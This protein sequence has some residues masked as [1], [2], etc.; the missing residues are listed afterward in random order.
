MGFSNNSKNTS[1]LRPIN[2]IRFET[3]GNIIFIFLGVCGF[4]ICITPEFIEDTLLNNIP[5]LLRYI[6]LTVCTT[7]FS[8]SLYNLIRGIN[9]SKD[10]N[11]LYN[12]TV[13]FFK[14]QYKTL[15]LQDREK[16][17]GL[18]DI[19]KE[20][21]D[22]ALKIILELKNISQNQILNRNNEENYFCDIICNGAI[23]GFIPANDIRDNKDGI[24]DSIIEYLT[25]GFSIRIIM[26]NHKLDYL[27]Q[28]Q[29]D[30]TFPFRRKDMINS[31]SANSA[32][33]EIN[34]N[35]EILR[36]ALD[37]IM[38]HENLRNKNIGKIIVRFTNC[39]PALQYHRVGNKVFV[40]SR[41]LGSEYISRPFINEYQNEENN[42]NAFKHYKKFFD[43]LW[44][45]NN[46]SWSDKNLSSYSYG[47]L[48][49]KPTNLVINPSLVFG[50]GIIAG[51]MK[52][53][54][55]TLVMILR[56]IDKTKIGPDAQPVRAFFTVINSS[57]NDKGEALRYNLIA[58]DRRDKDL[59]RDEIKDYPIDLR[60]VIGEAV[61]S[62]KIIFRTVNKSEPTGPHI[63][64]S[65]KDTILK[66]TGRI[67]SNDAVAIS[68]SVP[69]NANIDDKNDIP[70]IKYEDHD[71]IF[72][73]KKK[74]KY[75]SKKSRTIAVLTFE[76]HAS[77][78]SL[79][80]IPEKITINDNYYINVTDSEDNKDKK[81]IKQAYDRILNE[82]KRCATLIIDYLG[83]DANVG[84]L[85]INSSNA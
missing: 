7:F 74:P 71:R 47:N 60:H 48:P 85:Y 6:L 26:P 51:I 79:F 70:E 45:N 54:C 78:K 25:H 38:K 66:W 3:V 4:L 24:Q 83:L 58:V 5:V 62:E 61:I 30:S 21:C 55:N 9:V 80:D 41:M 23:A 32:Y 17:Y 82:A 28:L 13:Q 50:D 75:T 57:Q 34:T 77:I 63:P 37:T 76:F 81:E 36:T 43:E 49:I 44:K 19:Y 39:I 64:D 73:R 46:F 56:I 72:L 20:N 52:M 35:I 12:E 16:D 18:I 2:T 27:A 29:I 1:Q 15:Y 8:N 53:T 11:I 10:E 67:G 59:S 33:R 69:I 40:S 65:E 14:S 84:D 68:L 22:A 42:N 31:K